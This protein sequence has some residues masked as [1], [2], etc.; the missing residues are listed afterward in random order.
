MTSEDIFQR[1]VK[2]KLPRED[3]RQLFDELYKLYEECGK[4][5]LVKHLK[6]LIAQ[7]GA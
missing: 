5:D 4:E 6:D 7:L 1:Y 3:D 2:E